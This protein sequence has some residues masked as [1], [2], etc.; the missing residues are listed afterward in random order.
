MNKTYLSRK[1]S[2]R[3]SLRAAAR[4]ICCIL[5]LALWGPA[6]AGAQAQ[7]QPLSV[8]TI[9][10][11]LALTYKLKTAVRPITLGF[12]RSGLMAPTPSSPVR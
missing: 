8:N 9:S 5:T 3:L 6:R 1:I 2:V 10:G 7:S 11:K 12:T 4:M